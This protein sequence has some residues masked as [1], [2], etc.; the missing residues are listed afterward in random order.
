[1]QARPRAI[2][3]ECPYLKQAGLFAP[4]DYKQGDLLFSETAVVLGTVT[5]LGH[6]PL[7]TRDEASQE[8]RETRFRAWL[9]AARR[10]IPTL[11]WFAERGTL[12]GMNY[13][14][15]SKNILDREAYSSFI[16]E[17]E[18]LQLV[19]KPVDEHGWSWEE[20]LELR[21]L[22]RV[23]EDSYPV[24][25]EYMGG[26]AWGLGI[27][28]GLINHACH[29]N[30][31]LEITENEPEDCA[32]A[33][34]TM[35]VFA[36]KDIREG[37]EITTSYLYLNGSIEHYLHDLHI[38]FG[39][40]CQCHACQRTKEDANYRMLR[41][42]VYALKT[43]LQSEKITNSGDVLRY[44]AV[45]LDGY[46]LLD[47]NHEVVL[48]LYR[49]EAHAAARLGDTI[50]YHYFT[51]RVLRWYGNCTAREQ[52]M[53]AVNTLSN[54]QR[55][56]H[57]NSPNN[58][59]W[60]VWDYYE[61]S[62]ENLEEVMFM[63][64]PGRCGDTDY[65]LLQVVDRV[66]EEIPVER[67]EKFREDCREQQKQEEE[68]KRQAEEKALQD[69]EYRW[70]LQAMST[71]E[72]AKNIEGV[73]QSPPKK[74]KKSKK[75]AKKGT[76]TAKEESE[77][78]VED[79]ATC[80][81]HEG[82]QAE[83]TAEQSFDDSKMAIEKQ[84]VDGHDHQKIKVA[85]E[86]CLSLTA[87]PSFSESAEG[88]SGMSLVSLSR[89]LVRDQ[90]SNLSRVN[91]WT[92][93]IERPGLAEADARL[94]PACMAA[95]IYEE[96]AHA[97]TSFVALRLRKA[98]N[99]SVSSVETT[100]RGE[101]KLELPRTCSPCSKTVR[102]DL[103]TTDIDSVGRSNSPITVVFDF[104]AGQQARDMDD[105]PMSRILD[106]SGV[107]TEGTDSSSPADEA[108]TCFATPA[109]SEVE[110]TTDPSSAMSVQA[111]LGKFDDSPKTWLPL[112][113]QLPSKTRPVTQ[114]DGSERPAKDE[115]PPSPPIL[116]EDTLS[117][118]DRWNQT[119]ETSPGILPYDQHRKTDTLQDSEDNSG[120]MTVTPRRKTKEEH[121][122]SARTS[123]SLQDKGTA[124]R[125]A[126][127]TPG[128]RRQPQNLS[129]W[130]DQT[131][132]PHQA[133]NAADLRSEQTSSNLQV[134]INDLLRAPTSAPRRRQ[135]QTSSGRQDRPAAP[136]TGARTACRRSG[137]ISSSWQDQRTTELQ[138]A[139]ITAKHCPVKPEP[140]LVPLVPGNED[141]TQAKPVSNRKRNERRGKRVL[142]QKVSELE[143]EVEELRSRNHYLENVAGIV[144]EEDYFRT[145]E[146][147]KSPFGAKDGTSKSEWLVKKGL[148]NEPR[149]LGHLLAAKDGMDAPLLGFVLKERR[150]SACA[151]V[152]GDKVFVERSRLRGHTFGSD[153]SRMDW[154][155][156][157]E[158]RESKEV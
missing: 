6:R 127:M 118:T 3:Q 94:D 20:K 10:H 89:S 109:R 110:E 135:A 105:I 144:A 58:M 93:S 47:I 107:L 108:P 48:Q 46:W 157:A 152:E 91:E 49:H 82:S 126:P 106:K 67:V 60:S 123:S 96:D 116:F 78:V 131:T 132:V 40:H 30:A 85:A 155:K 134:R 84:D 136:Q 101:D 11:R 145:T 62:Q 86:P 137:Q 4:K 43:E 124:P 103:S 50:R 76:I 35:K 39:F 83:K 139:P 24:H 26:R 57:L 98:P 158:V 23:I 151:R 8:E 12:E 36:V 64:K 29:P 41:Q 28:N 146:A 141:V 81:G 113:E 73:S 149:D 133:A 97:A 104:H 102:A 33:T 32:V 5:E 143:Q 22:R 31:S 54:V 27:L 112:L 38:Y 14:E 17:S 88:L 122:R 56:K 53:S 45:L 117:R 55:Y 37:E 66:V 87:T 25:V 80:E 75:K 125:Q 156:Q 21:H 7:P 138:E 16:T 115:I 92:N 70:Q 147:Y 65:H 74:K 95:P 18:Y 121:R 19:G 142:E 130:Q 71:D 153:G 114:D 63:M 120:W 1:M 52:A 100:V 72:L 150:D 15:G 2:I 51:T 111:T 79:T 69:Q 119:E 9:K 61:M 128:R 148:S 140:P 77:P 129:S 68:K 42:D 99:S 154:L 59:G 13:P 34:V 90:E 44:T